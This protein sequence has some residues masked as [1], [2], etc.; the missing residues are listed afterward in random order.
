MPEGQPFAD[1][2]RFALQLY[3]KDIW[4]Q[5][6]LKIGVLMKTARTL[7]SVLG[8]LAYGPMTGYTLKATIGRTLGHF[9]SESFGQLYPTLKRL[10]AQGWVTCEAAATGRAK[11]TYAITAA[12]RAALADWLAAPWQPTA[13]RNEMLLKVFFAA[14]HPAGD[15]VLRAHLTAALESARVRLGT[16]RGIRGAVEMEDAAAPD[17]LCWLLTVDLGIENAA[18]Q[19]RWAEQALATLDAARAAKHDTRDTRASRSRGGKA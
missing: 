15:D 11:K 17:K 5:Y 18:A 14:Q 19:V 6:I 10:D 13:V 1:Q 4:C 2:E 8:L 3:L 12:G 9:W 7:W 16:M